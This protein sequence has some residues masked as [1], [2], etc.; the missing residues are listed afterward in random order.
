METP[1]S[2]FTIIE[3]IRSQGTT[4]YMIY[5]CV[6]IGIFDALAKKPRSAKEIAQE[7]S[8]VETTTEALLEMLVANELLTEDN[9][10]YSNTLVST[11]HLVSASPFFQGSSIKFFTCFDSLMKKHTTDLLQGKPL[12]REATDKEWA[13]TDIMKGMA[14]NSRRGAL[15]ATV[16]FATS[17]AGFPEMKQMCDIGGNHGSYT[18][19]L[20]EKNPNLKGEIIDLPNVTEI[21]DQFIAKEKNAHRV[22]TRGCDL[23]T[24]DLSE[25]TYDLILASHVLYAFM[26]DIAACAQKLYTSLTPN[27]WLVTHHLNADSS[28]PKRY[29]ALEQLRTKMMGYQTHFLKADF[30]ENVFVNAGFANIQI[31]FAGKQQ[32]ELLVAAQKPA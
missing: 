6:E 13:Q 12:G 20:L 3:N 1:K 28:L 4:Y 8:F 21:I 10:V 30:L 16:S 7:F 27:G 11:E 17:L 22:T 26:D 15:Q 5:K 23:R 24:E 31:Q 25:K 14:Q 19:A 2:D 18:L 29:T 9:G 32:Q